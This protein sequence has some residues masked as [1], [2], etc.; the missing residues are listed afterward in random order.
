MQR[1]YT[2]EEMKAL[3]ARAGMRILA[4]YSGFDLEEATSQSDRITLVLQK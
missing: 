1:V 2:F 3:V 4:A